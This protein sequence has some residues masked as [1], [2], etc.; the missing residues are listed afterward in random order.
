[1]IDPD[2]HTGSGG[3]GTGR[4]GLEAH[5]RHDLQTAGPLCFVVHSLPQ[6]RVFRQACWFGL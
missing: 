2:P 5:Q 1:M 4:Q 6:A 3:P